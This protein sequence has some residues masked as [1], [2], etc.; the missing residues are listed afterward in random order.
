MNFY[1]VD[2]IMTFTVSV[3]TL[4][5]KFLRYCKSEPI[6]YLLQVLVL[7]LEL[8]E[9]GGLLLHLPLEA[10]HVNVLLDGRPGEKSTIG[11][12]GNQQAA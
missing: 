11:L 1:F 12:K 10:D 2:N 4:Y 6:T 5:W 9:A 7:A 3:G 8:G